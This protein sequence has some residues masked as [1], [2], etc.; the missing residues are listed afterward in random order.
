MTR[1]P[2]S[3]RHHAPLPHPGSD[4]P[5]PV[6]DN[7][8]A[9]RRRTVAFLLL[10]VSAVTYND[11]LLQFLVPTG[12]DQANSYVSETFAANQPHRVLFSGIELLCA[13]L[14]IL[15]ALCAYRDDE[16]TL[17]RAGWAAIIA[18]ASFS[19]LDV[20]VPM[21]CA[22]S[23]DAQCAPVHA[24]HTTTSALVHVSLFASMVLFI[25]DARAHGPRGQA[26]HLRVHRWGRWLLA[27]SLVAA[28]STVGPL[29]GHP[30]GQ[31]VAQRLHLLSVG[32]WFLLLGGRTTP[33]RA[34]G[35]PDSSGE[36]SGR[37]GRKWYGGRRGRCA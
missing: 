20:L 8:H 23:V 7:P 14:L 25:A 27:F 24:W 4:G 29:L 34:P 9:G 30:G 22:P 37:W 6:P 10:A 36:R 16:R 28:V 26:G 5:G 13:C 1:E 35:E 12:L 21:E 3:G 15:A 33:L 32:L 2:A 18:F 19:I 17:A 31:G 11:W